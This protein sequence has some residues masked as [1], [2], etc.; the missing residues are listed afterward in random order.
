[1][2]MPP[3]RVKIGRIGMG[4]RRPSIQQIAGRDKTT[5]QYLY[6]GNIQRSLILVAAKAMVIEVQHYETNR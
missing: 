5:C 6:V 4:E 1:M 3:L 2:D